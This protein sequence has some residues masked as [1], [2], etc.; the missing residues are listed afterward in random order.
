MRRAGCGLSGTGY[1]VQ[2]SGL[3]AWTLLVCLMLGG[4]DASPAPAF[5]AA[6]PTRVTVAGCDFTVFRKD[7]RAEVVRLGWATQAERS[8]MRAA[9]IAAA[10]KATGCRVKPNSAEGD[11]GEIKVRLTC[12]Q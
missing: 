4:C 11:D 6:A 5:F 1:R 10:E 2:L 8:G 9:M 12:P 7:D 3:G